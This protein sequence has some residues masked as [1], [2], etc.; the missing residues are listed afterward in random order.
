[1]ISVLL[2]VF[3]GE[4]YL[5]EAVDSVLNQTFKDYELLIL[6]D[7]S[8][9]STKKIID[10]YVDDRIVY[11]KLEHSG[12]PSTLNYGLRISK[13]DFIA[14]MDADDICLPSRFEKQL[15]FL[16]SHPSI[17]LVGTNIIRFNELMRTEKKVKLPELDKHIKEQL[18][19]KCCIVHPSI[20]FKKDI[21]LSVGGYD[22]NE[23][24]E[25]WDLYI[26]LIDNISFHNLQ[27]Y[28]L[29]LRVH[30]NNISSNTKFIIAEEEFAK[31]LYSKRVK[32]KNLLKKDYT[33]ANFDLGYFY[34]LQDNNKFKELFKKSFCLDKTNFRYFYFYFISHY[35]RWLVL[36][37]RKLSLTKLLYPLKM[38]DK[39]NL[40]FR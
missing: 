22:I 34:Y 15:E 13:Y 12:L 37:L 2:P 9:D 17:D 38:L 7:G 18:P 1:M 11:Q 16:I 4:K 10:T 35:F 39:N 8:T 24:V 20:M 33:K 31:T 29:K 3:N 36:L 5:K 25:D 23:I 28:F 32:P 14:R 26:K 21:I 30:G 19:R 6:D 40:F 27:D